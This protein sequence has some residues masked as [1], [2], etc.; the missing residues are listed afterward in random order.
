MKSQFN[1]KTRL[2]IEIKP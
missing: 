2:D 1:M